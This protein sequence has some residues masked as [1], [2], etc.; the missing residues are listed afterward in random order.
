MTPGEYALIEVTDSGTG[1]PQEI[2]PRIF[3]PF[4]S[5]KERDHGTGLGLSMA[6][7]FVKQSGGHIS[8]Y[9]EVGI[10]TTFRIYLPRV[11]D[12]G[13]TAEPLVERRKDVARPRAG[14]TVLAVEDNAS[15]RRVVVR[16]L[17][18][19]GYR[20]LEAGNAKEAFALLEEGG[21][22]LVFTDVIMPGDMDG[23]E[24]AR[25]AMT[26]WPSVKVVLTSGFPEHRQS[27]A[28]APSGLRLLGKPYRKD[29]LARI[30]QGAFGN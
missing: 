15:L 21:V 10:G 30:L 25:V 26:R 27:E 7:G 14:T 8:V 5:T 2:M 13:Q 17:G 24:L 23:Y 22:D 4:F 6:F 20:V 11:F 28:E 9:S 18:E 19:L 3:E 16:Q 29:D 1:I 12:I